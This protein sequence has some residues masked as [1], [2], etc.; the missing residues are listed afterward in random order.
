MVSKS[1]RYAKFGLARTLTNIPARNRAGFI[2]YDMCK[3][4]KKPPLGIVPKYIWE[5][6][7]NIQRFNEVCRAISDYYNAGLEINIE[8]IQEYNEFVKNHKKQ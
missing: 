7:V 1:N 5:E 2:F 8:W 6:Q 3:N 4:R